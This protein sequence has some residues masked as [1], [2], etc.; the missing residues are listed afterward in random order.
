MR[1]LLAAGT[2]L[3]TLAVSE[4]VSG[5]AYADWVN[6]VEDQVS[7]TAIDYDYPPDVIVTGAFGFCDEELQ[8]LMAGSNHLATTTEFERTLSGKMV[9]RVS[10]LRARQSKA[11][12]VR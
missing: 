10:S 6:C 2:F 3:I 12:E 9:E 7:E 11:T 8:S 5:H 1:S 4:S